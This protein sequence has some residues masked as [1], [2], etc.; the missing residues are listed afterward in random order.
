MTKVDSPGRSGVEQATLSEEETD[1]LDLAVRRG[2]E[3]TRELDTQ[4]VVQKLLDYRA[5]IAQAAE[6]AKAEFDSTFDGMAPQ[7][8]SFGLDTIHQGYFGWNSWDNLPTLSAGSTQTW[9]DN[10]V[11]DN[12]SG[13]GGVNN[14]LT[15]GEPAVHVIMAVGSY[16]QSPKISRLSWRLNDQPRPAIST[17]FAF[18]NTD[19]RM[20]WL[21]TPVVLKE[22]DDL[23]AQVYA[24][25]DGQDAPYLFGL[26]FVQAKDMRELQPSEMAGTDTSNI[27][28]E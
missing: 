18:Q 13:S 4:V 28:V 26:S 5:E 16:A 6:I 8:G 3:D 21:D 2:L 11:P 25:E 20:K 24:D 9:L 1:K 15:V 19:L 23:F 27:V 12:L 7:S 14:P 17:D 10:S 22:D